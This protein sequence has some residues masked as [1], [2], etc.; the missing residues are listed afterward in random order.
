MVCYLD[1]SVFIIMNNAVVTMKEKIN[2]FNYI[3]LKKILRKQ[4]RQLVKCIFS[5]YSNQRAGIWES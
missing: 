4:K 2:T 3:A 5:A 1:V